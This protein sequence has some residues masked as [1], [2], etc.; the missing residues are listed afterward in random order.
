MTNT[1]LIV[2]VFFYNRPELVRGCLDALSESVGALSVSIRVF[3]DGAKNSIDSSSVQLVRDEVDGYD[4]GHFL[5]VKIFKNDA[6]KGLAES[7][8]A[9]VS[10]V[11]NNFETVIV[12]EDDLIVGAN[13]LTF[14]QAS[15][16]KYKDQLNVGSVSGFSFPIYNQSDNDAYFHPRPTSWGWGTWSD[17]WQKS[18]WKVDADYLRSIGYR[19]RFFNT[20]GADMDRMLKAYLNK[21]SNS[22]AIRWALAHKVNEWVAVTPYLSKVKNLGFGDKNATN[23]KVSNNF[24]TIF[25]ESRFLGPYK[26]PET[27]K[28]NAFVLRWVNTFNSNPIRFCQKVLP[29]GL[30]L[31]VCRALYGL[32]RV[33]QVF[34]RANK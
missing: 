28:S 24:Y 8:I 22:W 21:K 11:L 30:W 12:V 23:T 13:F 31:Y 34:F 16:C 15:L 27:S 29:N 19:P 10:K 17:R 32:S 26:Y 3:I 6:N 5:D 14:M 4:F 1:H 7:I 25:D 33:F 2:C 18:H 20:L 9:G